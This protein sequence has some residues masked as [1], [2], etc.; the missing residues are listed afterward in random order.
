MRKSPPTSSGIISRDAATEAARKKASHDRKGSVVVSVTGATR[1]ALGLALLAIALLGA[2]GGG[3]EE[4]T[5][6][7]STPS[8][9]TTG[10]GDVQRFFQL[11]LGNRWGFNF[12]VTETGRPPTSGFEIMKATGTKTVAGY[13]TVVVSYTGGAEEYYH[14]NNAGLFFFGDN[15]GDPVLAAIVPYQVF[16]FPLQ[17]GDSFVQVDKTGIDFGADLDGDGRNETLDIRSVVT[18]AGFET[19]AVPAGSFDNCA[20]LQTNIT[21]TLT[22]SRNGAKVTILGVITEWY[23]PRIGPIKRFGT[24]SGNGY[25][26]VIEY[27][28][29]SYSVDGEKSDAVP[30]AVTSVQP[31]PGGVQVGSQVV[32][33]F[34]EEIDPATLNTATF[35]VRDPANQQV[36]G[37]IS[38]ANKT[39]TFTQAMPLAQGVYSATL[40][41]GIQDVAGNALSADYSWS[42]TVDRTAPTVV[43]TAPAANATNV[44]TS[45]SISVTFSEEMDPASLNPYSS[46]TVSAGGSPVSGNLSYSN[47][48]ATFTPFAPLARGTVYTATLT[49]AVTDVSGNHLSSSYSWSFT[50][51][52]SLFANYVNFPT[53]SW[54]EAVAIGDVNG[55]GRNDVV[56][57]TSFY[58]DDAN[59]YKVFVF[60]QN[61]NGTLALPV[62]YATSS[63]YTCR[64]ATVGIGDVNQDGRN[65]V[66]IGDSGCGLEVLLQKA[67]GTLASGVSY[68]SADSHKI[69]IADLNNDGRM[70]VVGIGWGTNTASVWLQNAGGTLDPPVVYSV[71]H[72][73]YDDL[74]A[75][76]VNGDGLTDVVVMSG[77]ALVPNLG[78]LTQ[79]ADGS[80]DAPAY[81]SVAS[82]TL[83]AGVAIG[84]VNGDSRND[85]VVSYG[86]NRPASR[87]GVFSQNSSGTLDPVVSSTSYD[88]PEAVEIADVTGDGRK[89]IIVLHGGWMQMGLYEQQ[90]DGT[91]K[92]EELF[93]I[94]YASHYNPHGLAVGDIS[95]DGRNDVV[96][97]DYN[98][99]LVVLYNNGPSPPAVAP[100]DGSA[101]VV[102]GFSGKR[103][104]R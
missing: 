97:A 104:R 60:L 25:T 41:T 1:S 19:I 43:S 61:A 14:K 7:S 11:T 77:Q 36:A 63:T 38:Y 85:V 40:T 74:E 91:L 79:K 44:S 92:A 89:D 81:Y 103:L 78:V 21:E 71:T 87:I 16:R 15:S 82:N 10:P 83:T 27:A 33:V 68:P 84:D 48:T 70:D 100:L 98:Y 80:L 31:G 28:A 90:P 75:G 34:S 22:Y 30:P 6:G 93:S 49:T 73:G 52:A 76:D 26:Q 39:A 54:P 69:R 32:A 88:I 5:S 67:D 53:G 102:P 3:G 94:P 42:F 24:Y 99:G 62:K 101:A 4:S 17:A 51:A 59:D 20:R 9:P 58:F 55:D 35:S 23:A 13:S 8:I 46:F 12:S 50:T 18:V 56:M 45:A 86:G 57:T 2:C 72:G 37:A 47:K 95:G 64:A 29:A 65:D 96:I 66:V